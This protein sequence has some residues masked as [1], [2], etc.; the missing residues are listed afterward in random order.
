VGSAQRSFEL[1]GGAHPT[2][3]FAI[4]NYDPVSS[5]NRVL[6]LSELWI[7]VNDG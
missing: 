6:F 7:F 3:G 4:Q 5:G 1:V 2:D